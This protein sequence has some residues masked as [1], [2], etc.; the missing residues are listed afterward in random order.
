MADLRG[1]I[2]TDAKVFWFSATEIM[3][4]VMLQRKDRL[5]LH[6]GVDTYLYVEARIDAEGRPYLYFGWEEYPGE[7][8]KLERNLRG[9]GHA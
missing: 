4:M 9:I 1:G 5:R 3:R 6:Q 8:E 7:A 2:P